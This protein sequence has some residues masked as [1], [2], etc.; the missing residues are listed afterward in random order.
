MCDGG[1]FGTSHRTEIFGRQRNCPRAENP[2]ASLTP[3]SAGCYRGLGQGLR[4]STPSPWSISRKT[5]HA[6]PTLSH[7]RGPGIARNQPDEIARRRLIGATIF[8]DAPFHEDGGK[9]VILARRRNTLVVQ[10]LATGPIPKAS[11]S[12]RMKHIV[13]GCHPTRKLWVYAW[14]AKPS[15]IRACESTCLEPSSLRTADRPS[16]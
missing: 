6:R 15:A 5:R 3:D 13:V 8:R 12:R 11:R 10:M 9:L 2:I 1:Y 16:Q 4:T 7:W 14:T